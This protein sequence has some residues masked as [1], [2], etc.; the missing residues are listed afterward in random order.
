VPAK[1]PLERPALPAL[2]SRL[3]WPGRSV[4]VFG[5]GAGDF[6]AALRDGLAEAGR[7]VHEVLAE[8]RHA[9]GYALEPQGAATV[10]HAH[11]DALLEALGAV[12]ARCGPGSFTI[13]VGAPF[14]AAVEAD[15]VVWIEG[16]ATLLTLPAALRPVARRADLVLEEPREGV[17][18]ALARRLA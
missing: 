6:A 10:I 1:V 12:G 13:G 8:L 14:A 18:R 3:A 17:A 5:P 4:A 2:P 15:R 11:P 16:S 7:E 9:A